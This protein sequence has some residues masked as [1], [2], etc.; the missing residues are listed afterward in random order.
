MLYTPAFCYTLHLICVAS[1]RDRAASRRHLVLRVR[2][3]PNCILQFAIQGRSMNARHLT[4][5][6]LKKH[7]CTECLW[8]ALQANVQLDVLDVG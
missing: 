1:L 4:Q 3:N 8:R 7:Y 2:F 6:N 5:R